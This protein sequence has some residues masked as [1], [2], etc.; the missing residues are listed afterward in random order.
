DPRIKAVG[1]TGSRSGGTAL[2]QTAQARP[3]PI[4]VYAEMSSINPVFLLPEA[5]RARGRELGEAFIGSLTMG[6]GQFCT[7]PG[8]VI[9]VKGEALDGFVEA[10]AETIRSASAQTML[11]PGI[12]DAYTQGVNTLADSQSARE[13]ARGPAGDGPN[14]CQAGLFVADAQDFLKDDAL[15]AEVFGSTS[16]VV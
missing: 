15:Q 10:A 14:Q 6:A 3:E 1:F 13:V 5:L 11:T 8:L 12:H 16:L 2:M 4:P 9:A 7:N